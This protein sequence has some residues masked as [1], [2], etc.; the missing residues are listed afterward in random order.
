MRLMLSTAAV[1][2]LTTASV[3]WADAPHTPDFADADNDRMVTAD[4]AR[5]SSDR[6]FDAWDA[7]ADDFLTTEEFGQ[8]W[9]SVRDRE[10]ITTVDD[11]SAMDP[12][13]DEAIS[14]PEFVQYYERNYTTAMTE[15]GGDLSVDQYAK[16]AAITPEESAQFDFNGDA[17][18]SAEEAGVEASERFN[19]LDL[20]G[21]GR[22]TRNE[23]GDADTRKQ[24]RFQR[25]DADEDNRI[26][27]AEWSDAMSASYDAGDV[28]ADGQVSP[29]EHHMSR[30]LPNASVD[31]K[32][33]S[34]GD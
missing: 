17:M 30:H 32:G 34:S 3:A 7:D 29:F 14:A 10:Q 26:S 25:L 12:D 2:A 33:A 20:D 24:N 6:T 15:A 5:M 4:E 19:A 11:M 21:D 13:G 31:V 1:V 8:T 9:G 28:N 23:A 27:R 22:L 18:I 16:T